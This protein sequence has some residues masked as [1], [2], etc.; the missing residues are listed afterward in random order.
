MP[1]TGFHHGREDHVEGWASPIGFNLGVI[2]ELVALVEGFTP[3]VWA[4]QLIATKREDA[5]NSCK[6]FNQ[7]TLSEH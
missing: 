7:S 4:F 3:A 2:R 6:E 5:V 1:R